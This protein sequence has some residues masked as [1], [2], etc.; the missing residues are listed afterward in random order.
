MD[1]L[2]GILIGFW[3][4]GKEEMFS[5]FVAIVEKILA[6]I[7]FLSHLY[8][9]VYESLVEKEIEM[10]SIGK[11]DKV[12][13]IGCGAVPYTSQ[14]IA[15]KTGAS[16]VGIDNDSCAIKLAEKYIRGKA[17]LTG[18]L[19]LQLVDTR[20]FL[21]SDFDVVV[22][23]HTIR[24]QKEVLETIIGSMKQGA[25]LIYRKRK[26]VFIRKSMLIKRC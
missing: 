3:Y 11:E 10:A 4:V 12:V 24:P 9:K 13:H 16:V 22:I 8:L 20:N 7:K 5:R 1:I 17:N 25:R 19:T 26:F 21:I 15:E 14:L 2:G 6:N 18:K 23:S